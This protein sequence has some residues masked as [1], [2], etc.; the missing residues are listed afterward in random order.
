MKKVLMSSVVASSLLLVNVFAQATTTINTTGEV[1]LIS[2]QPVVMTDAQY[3]KIGSWSG[4]VKIEAL[5]DMLIEKGYLKL[6][7][8]AKKGKYGSLTMKAH[9]KW[10]A[11]MKKMKKDAMMEKKEDKMKM[12]TSSN[13]TSTSK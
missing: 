3:M 8:T 1:N 7:E 2:P 11:D 5:Q 9:L 10:K 6:P 12:S 13:A 4:K